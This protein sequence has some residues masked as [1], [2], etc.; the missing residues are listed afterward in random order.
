[1]SDCHVTEKSVTFP[2]EG[3]LTFFTEKNLV[4]EAQKSGKLLERGVF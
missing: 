2:T 3:V 4:L 1:M